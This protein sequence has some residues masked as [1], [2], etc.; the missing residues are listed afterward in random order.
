MLEHFQWKNEAETKKHL[1]KD[2]DEVGEELCDTLY[3][4]LLMTHYFDIDIAALFSKKMEKNRR[5]YPI[6]KAEGVIRNIM[7]YGL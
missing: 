1:A 3:W 4:I 6:E 5:K 7:R 2:R